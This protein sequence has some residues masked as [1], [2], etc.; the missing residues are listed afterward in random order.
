MI[1]ST[2]LDDRCAPVRPRPDTPH[3]VVLGGVMG[4]VMKMGP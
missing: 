2:D 4:G 3:D 1:E